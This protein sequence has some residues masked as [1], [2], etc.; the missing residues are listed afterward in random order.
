MKKTL[1]IN[2]RIEEHI[3]ELASSETGP[4]YLYDSESICLSCRRFLDIPY[5]AKSLHFAMMANSNPQFIRIIREN[6]LG[7]FVNSRLHL[8]TAEEIG[9]S[10]NEIVFAASALDEPTMQRV[11]KS[12][13]TLILDSMGQLDQWQ[14]LYPGTSVGI[15][16]NIGEMVKPKKTL[17]GYFLG[18]HSRL[19]LTPDQI[20]GLKGDPGISGLHIYVGTNITDINYFLECY[21]R[22]T[23]LSALFPELRYLDFG[24]GFGSGEKEEETFN[25][26]LYG[27]KVSLLMEQVSAKAGREIILMLEPGRIIGMI[28]GYFVCRVV[29]IKHH[30]QQQLVGVNASSVQFPRPLFYPD[31]TYHPAKIIHRNGEADPSPSVFSSIYG[32]STYSRDFLAR[33]IALPRASKGD[34]IILGHA[35][36]YCATAH[37]HFLGFPKAKELFL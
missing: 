17:A 8:E 25:M 18:K 36:A 35:G 26:K 19:G 13:A 37:T 4:F 6:G 10:G 2:Q 28:A 20:S 12:G 1:Y 33:N 5:P 11:K 31:E 29:D 15:R 14:N 32:C 34:I 27:E 23:E 7:I 22:L 9:Y 30:N 3:L 16:C 21:S 24:G